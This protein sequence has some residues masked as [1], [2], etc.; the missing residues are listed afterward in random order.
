[1]AEI[2]NR[3]LQQDSN[4]DG[5]PDL[6]DR[7]QSD[8]KFGPNKANWKYR[9]ALVMAV[10]VTS[11]GSGLLMVV[12][13]LWMVLFGQEDLKPNLLN[14]GTTMFWAM[15]QTATTTLGIYLGIA[16]ND[17]SSYRKEVGRLAASLPPPMPPQSN[18]QYGGGYG[19][20]YGGGNRGSIYDYV[21]AEPD[22]NN[23][24]PP[25]PTPITPAG[26]PTQPKPGVIM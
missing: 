7:L 11:Y 10:I 2:L 26:P 14:F 4:G 25:M 12:V 3:L 22:A 24:P 5:V 6:L 23:P 8:E 9:R 19:N 13:W 16:Q 18:N 20:N 1:M 21:G 15:N 17:T